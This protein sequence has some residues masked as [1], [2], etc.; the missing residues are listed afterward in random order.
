MKENNEYF[1]NKI[2]ELADYKPKVEPDWEAF[3]AKNQQGI[4]GLKSGAGK[5]SFDKFASSASFKYTLIA[6]SVIAIFIAGYYIISDDKTQHTPT[7]KTIEQPANNQNN[8]VIVPALPSQE[9]LTNPAPAIDLNKIESGNNVT[10]DSKNQK[11]EIPVTII[12]E[13]VLA[14]PEVMDSI[15]DDKPVIIKKTVIIKD[16]IRVKRP[17]GK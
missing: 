2:R 6:I 14:E 16:T 10:F 3:Y 9:K 1:D 12:D 11:S 13:K 4:E 17:D 7:E 5:S 8:E 15:S